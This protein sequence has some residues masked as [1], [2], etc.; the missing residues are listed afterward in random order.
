MIS[1]VFKSN[2]TIKAVSADLQ[3]FVGKTL[4]VI[5]QQFFCCS[6]CQLFNSKFCDIGAVL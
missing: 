1:G 3:N 5:T 2:E 6:S 4:M